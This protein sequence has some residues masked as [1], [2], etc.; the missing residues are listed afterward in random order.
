MYHSA[1][2]VRGL[3]VA[4]EHEAECGT[5]GLRGTAATLAQNPHEEQVLICR[6]LC[7]H[8]LQIGRWENSRSK[9][10]MRR[11]V[12]CAIF[13]QESTREEPT[14]EAHNPPMQT[15]FRNLL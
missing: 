6:L 7:Y 15:R 4:A 9:Q 8:V 11:A 1:L 13:G 2:A 10:S 5:G 14:R 3:K 12:V